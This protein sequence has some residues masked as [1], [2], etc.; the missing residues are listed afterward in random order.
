MNNEKKNCTDQSHYAHT[1]I[2]YTH[3]HNTH[4]RKNRCHPL[5]RFTSQNKFKEKSLKKKKK[6]F[7]ANIQYSR[8]SMQSQHGD[9]HDYKTVIHVKLVRKIGRRDI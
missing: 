9:L 5:S 6:N 7:Y 4:A 1:Y 8:T 3:T 2:H